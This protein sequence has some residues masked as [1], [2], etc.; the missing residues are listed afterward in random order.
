MESFKYDSQI[1]TVHE[2]AQGVVLRA[3][4]DRTVTGDLRVLDN[5]R[6][7][8]ETC[9][10]SSSFFGKV[11]KDIQP[12]MRRI[13]TVWMFKV[14]EDQLCEEEV[15]PQAVHYMDSYLSRFPIE[16]SKLQLLGAACMFLASKMRETVPLTADK[17]SIYT[18]NS[19]S[20]TDIQQWEV[21][22]ASKLNWCLASVVPSD[23]LEPILHALPFVRAPHLQHIRR[24][25]H[26]YIAL[27]TMDC[28]FLAFLPSTLTCACVSSAIQKLKMVDSH[29]L[30]DSVIKFLASLLAADMSTVVCCCELLGSMLELSLPSCLQG[31][32]GRR[33]VHSSEISYTPADIQ[34]VVLTPPT[35]S[36]E[37]KLKH[38][39]LS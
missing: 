34:D 25:V 16:R 14:C 13:V 6:A 11:Q 12:H 5:L 21:M 4:N 36:Q 19:V 24:H 29:D 30:S 28:R 26:S 17:L 18:D 32:V 1:K 2:A 27:A 33:E 9:R 10:V 15:F 22:V 31:E 38:S 39:S 35:P 23:F 7:L 8:E 20:V 37:I 3:G